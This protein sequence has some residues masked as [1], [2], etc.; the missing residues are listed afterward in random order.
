MA[1]FFT[2]W[3]L[4]T[5]GGPSETTFRPL[6]E[7]E[8]GQFAHFVAVD[9]RLAVEIELVLRLHPWQAGELEAAFEAPLVATAPLRI[10]RLGEKALVVECAVT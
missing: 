4:P 10:E 7:A 5:P 8:T 1:R 6:D 3:A 9:G 2:R